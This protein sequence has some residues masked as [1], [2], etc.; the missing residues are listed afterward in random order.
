MIGLDLSGC[1]NDWF[2]PKWMRSYK[3]SKITNN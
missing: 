2:G 3:T 1:V